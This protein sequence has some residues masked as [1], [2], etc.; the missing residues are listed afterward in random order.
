MGLFFH[1][2]SKI[3]ALDS[4][5]LIFFADF[6]QWTSLSRYTGRDDKIIQDKMMRDDWIDALIRFFSRRSRRVFKTRIRFL[7][8]SLF[9]MAI[10]ASHF[11][12]A[13]VM[14]S[15]LPSSFALD[16]PG[17]LSDSPAVSVNSFF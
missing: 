11:R 2:R 4:D 7:R 13:I 17:D 6:K 5:F 16:Q 14:K 9:F 1:V 3:N 12:S 10:S 15:F 8:H